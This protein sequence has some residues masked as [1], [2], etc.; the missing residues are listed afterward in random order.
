MKKLLSIVLSLALVFSAV[1]GAITVSADGEPPII[2]PKRYD[3]IFPESQSNI[4][5]FED[6]TIGSG[7]GN[8]NICSS[9]VA[10]T[11]TYQTDGTTA[12][13]DIRMVSDAYSGTTAMKMTVSDDARVAATNVYFAPINSGLFADDT[14]KFLYTTAYIKTTADFDGRV[15]FLLN[16]GNIWYDCYTDPNGQSQI[17]LLDVSGDTSRYSANFTTHP[18]SDYSDWTKVSAA[19]IK[20]SRKF[21]EQELYKW[22][23][24]FDGN[25]YS[26]FTIIVSGT[27]GSV[28]IDNISFESNKQYDGCLTRAN[29]NNSAY[30][31]ADGGFEDTYVW[32]AAQY[33][34]QDP[35]QPANSRIADKDSTV[36]HSGTY[37]LR[38][39]VDS[40][41]TTDGANA[42][43]IGFKY[44]K[45]LV[46]PDSDYY[47][48]AWV[49]FDDSFDGKP[50]VTFSKNA[51][52]Y[53]D[54]RFYS[55]TAFFPLVSSQ[56]VI[57]STNTAGHISGSDMPNGWVLLRTPVI[58]A[59]TITDWLTEADASATL[60][61][62][63]VGFSGTG[64]IWLDDVDLV[65]VED[66]TPVASQNWPLSLANSSVVTLS[67]SGDTDVYFT[68]DGSDPRFSTT[69]KLYN[70]NKPV[71]LTENTYLLTVG[72][73]KETGDFS[74]VVGQYYIV[75][76]SRYEISLDAST[77]SAVYSDF[78]P[79][80]AKNDFTLDFDVETS[81]LAS[82]ATVKLFLRGYGYT[83]L[84]INETEYTGAYADRSGYLYKGTDASEHISYNITGLDNGYQGGYLIIET[85]SNTGTAEISNIEIKT[86]QNELPIIGAQLEDGNYLNYYYDDEDISMSFLLTNNTAYYQDGTLTYNVTNNTTG[87]VIVDGSDPIEILGNDEDSADIDILGAKDFGTY[88]L[89]MTYT[90]SLNKTTLS[91]ELV[92]AR[93]HDNSGITANS[94]IGVS[95]HVL[96]WTPEKSEAEYTEMFT[97][98][99]QLGFKW[100]RVDVMWSEVEAEAGVYALPSIYE[101]VLG[102]AMD[103]GLE[104]IVILN[105]Y[106]NALYSSATAAEKSAAYAAFAS[107]VAS[108][109][110]AT[111]FEILNESNLSLAA[112]V[113]AQIVKDA[114][115]AIKTAKPAAKVIAGNVSGH[116]GGY[117]EAMY[118]ADATVLN[119]VDIWAVHPYAYQSASSNYEGIN[120]STY[121]S[122]FNTLKTNYLTPNNVELWAGEF[123]YPV[124]DALN[125]VTATQSADY[126]VRAYLSMNKNGIY[127]VNQ[128]T[129]DG[130]SLNYYTENNF[131]IL[132]TENKETSV[133]MNNYVRVMD[134]FTLDS[135]VSNGT[136]GLYVNKY[137]NEYNDELYAVWST[138]GAQNY[139]VTVPSDDYSSYDI[140]GNKI[141]AASG[142]QITVSAGE[143]VTYVMFDDTPCDDEMTYN[144]IRNGNLENGQKLDYA[145]NAAGASVET[146]EVLA[147]NYS[148]K[149]TTLSSNTDTYA[150]LY[151]SD[152][153]IN[154]GALYQLKFRVKAAQ[155]GMEGTFN[156]RPRSRDI[157]GNVYQYAS[158]YT[159]DFYALGSGSA[160]ASIPTKWKEYTSAPFSVV[161]ANDY[162]ELHLIFT[163]GSVYLDNI[164]LVPVEGSYDK[165]GTVTAAYDSENNKMILTG[166]PNTGYR[167]DS[168]T[169]K[170]RVADG[171]TT[172]INAA[173]VSDNVFEYDLGGASCAPMTTAD[174]STR[175]YKATFVSYINDGSFESGE[176]GYSLYTANHSIDT[177]NVYNGAKS[178]HLSSNGAGTGVDFGKGVNVESLGLDTNVKYKLTF[179]MKAS[180]DAEVWIYNSFAITNNGTNIS[181][182]VR[183]VNKDYGTIN[184]LG[185]QNSF[186]TGL[187]TEWHEYESSAFYIFGETF[188]IT[189]SIR[190]NAGE[191]WLDDF[192]LIPVTDSADNHGKVTYSYDDS[193]MTVTATAERGYELDSLSVNL[194]NRIG[195]NTTTVSMPLTLV[196]QSGNSKTYSFAFD[197][198]E[199]G[200][201]LIFAMPD[202]A[203]KLVNATFTKFE[204]TLTGDANNDGSVDVRDLVVLKKYIAGMDVVINIPNVDFN[205]DETLNAAD[206]TALVNHLLGI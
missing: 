1:A 133:A 168:V 38:M 128:Y 69:A 87:E 66:N 34:F 193:T 135:V 68:T 179:K 42:S 152:A 149:I 202:S 203:Y 33:G 65:K 142:G 76:N 192:A 167:L 147:G 62:V 139:N 116:G 162:L 45:E 50:Y 163:P 130:N 35:A 25:N 70:P 191:I 59:E 86:V 157:F 197:P 195:N 184:L 186:A 26:G 178:L 158:I 176:P 198:P 93:V 37:S 15:V 14:S 75:D 36:S 112:S 51:G 23:T 166:H 175:T 114:A 27:T 12:S 187:D 189:S 171:S 141:A 143:S 125:G 79:L 85:E 155:K 57:E 196:S 39:K 161:S 92:F 201:Y 28:W 97:A 131:G 17:Y 138:S 74:K 73:D 113:Y 13:T 205:E 109:S 54:G 61:P 32:Y 105:G 77:D 206:L 102:Y 81:G 78:I 55:N 124:C 44:N 106:N 2:T 104:P 110:G 137:T 22:D 132:Q 16:R 3:G 30:V 120:I 89:E 101:N 136:N 8:F 183:T 11:G 145:N 146:E 64:K 159:N 180:A 126:T 170:L 185:A 6:A 160:R 164:E 95:S 41:N 121:D 83:K 154:V 148:N 122:Y 47:V 20:E 18:V 60:F 123:G 107:Y 177:V 134:G 31:A 63:F 199:Q 88:T 19:N 46:D 94:D 84:T 151:I 144:N 49:K 98:Y 140:Y 4:F 82:D 194:I 96:Q 21:K 118:T 90:D 129:V 91:K 111:Y 56:T 29:Q 10:A 103:C 200:S 117:L 190:M 204:Q 53:S 52:G 173:K 188:Y 172:T 99:K 71:I 9:A 100:L 119:D 169:V 48:Q 58:P 153:N 115:A 156:V 80:Y 150:N 67:T 165:N 7:A 40:I 24:D 72:M 174:L 181:P 5:G 43:G 127:H 182:S 108:E